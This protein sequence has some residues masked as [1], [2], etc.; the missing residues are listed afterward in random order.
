MSSSELPVPS[1]DQEIFSEFFNCWLSEIE[2]DLRLLY[3]MAAA[4]PPPQGS[5]CIDALQVQVLVDRIVG[6]HEYY[7]RAKSA[8][9]RGDVLPMFSPTWTSSTENLFYWVGGYRPSLAFHVLYS[10]SGLQLDSQLAKGMMPPLGPDLE[11]EGDL[12]D[13]SH[14]QLV[15]IDSLMRETIRHEREISEQEASAQESVGSTSMV[16][17]SH[18][19]T[20]ALLE[21]AAEGGGLTEPPPT[22][23]AEMKESRVSMTKALEMADTLRLDTL[24]GIVKILRPLQ[25]VHFLIAVSELILRVHEFGKR[26]DVTAK[27]RTASSNKSATV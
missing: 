13:L 4:S 20:E 11:A 3:A 1:S 21:P 16:A 6:H 26:V 10:K 15:R 7:I 25:A 18:Q 24:K 5:Q 8:S 12:G 14:S 27:L 19:V 2:R 9:A 23:D 17:I 22:M